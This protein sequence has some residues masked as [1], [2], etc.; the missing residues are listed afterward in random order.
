MQHCLDATHRWEFDSP[1]AVVGGWKS[2]GAS[3]I[4]AALWTTNTNMNKKYSYVFYVPESQLG[5]VSSGGG[6]ASNT[7][8]DIMVEIWEIARVKFF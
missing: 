3:L 4:V 1:G 8:V 7:S 6:V 2:N 5:Y